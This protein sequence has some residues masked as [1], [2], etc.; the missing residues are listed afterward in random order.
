MPI[1]TCHLRKLLERWIRRLFQTT[2][3]LCSVL[4]PP[5]TAGPGAVYPTHRDRL[6]SSY[7]TDPAA[8]R[9]AAAATARAAACRSATGCTGASP[10]TAAAA[11]A[12]A[13]S[14][15]TTASALSTA[16]G[17]LSA[18]TASSGLPGRPAACTS[19]G[20]S[21]TTSSRTSSSSSCTA[22]W[23]SLGGPRSSCAGS[24]RLTCSL[25]GPD[26]L[27]C[28]RAAGLSPGASTSPRR[29]SWTFSLSAC[30]CGQRSTPA[31]GAAAPSGCS[32]RSASP[33][34][35]IRIPLT[36]SLSSTHTQH[37][38]SL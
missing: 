33:P 10:T 6:C 12:A 14:S 32:C 4:P 16:A 9:A 31:T 37:G 1:C 34:A 20:S 30:S 25:A 21:F 15:A 22:S 29:S 35:G 8:A 24:A 18:P 38:Q 3:F 19:T 26:P 36:G 13:G 23:T 5:C 17:R 28:S 27:G 2:T 7:A 11:T